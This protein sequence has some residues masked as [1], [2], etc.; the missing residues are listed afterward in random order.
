MPLELVNPK[1]LW[2]LGLLAPLIVLYI[3]K[4]RRARLKVPSTW[5]WS[6]AQ[7]DLLAKSPFKKL[8]VQVPLILQILA[9]ILLALALARPST[10]GGAI[11]GDH[12]ALVVDTSASMS[13]TEPDGTPRI[14]LAR[15]AARD[16]VR[17]LGPGADAMIIEAGREARIASP[18]DRD[19]RRLEAAIER[20]GARDVEGNLGRAIAIAFAGEGAKIVVDAAAR[21][22][23]RERGGRV[24]GGYTK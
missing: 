16:V 3:L 8:I 22:R 19:V 23:L 2:L 20:I 11:V 18:L 13:A 1:G 15:R 24:S 10:R 12:V 9:L 21:L 4:V 7:R 5:L 6:A 17:A 14:E